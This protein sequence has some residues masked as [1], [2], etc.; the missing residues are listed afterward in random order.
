MQQPRGNG[1]TAGDCQQVRNATLAVEMHLQPVAGFNPD[2][3]LCAPGQLPVTTFF[4]NMEAGTGNFTFSAAAGSQRWRTDTSFAHSGVRAL[5]ANDSPPALADSSAEFANSVAVPANAFLHFAHAF[6]FQ[7]PNLDGGVLEFSTTGGATW[8][9]AAPLIDSNG[10]RA[11]I[12]AGANPLAGRA[13]FVGSSHGYISSRANLASLAGQSVRFRWRMGLDATTAIWGWWLDDVRIYTCSGL[14]ITSVTPNSAQQG[15]AN[16][17]IAVTGQATHFA[18][19]QTVATFGPGVIVHGTTV[20]DATH[21]AVHVSVPSDAA[22]GAREVLMTTGTEVAVGP[23]MFTVTPGATL[24]RITPNRGQPGQQNLT[25]EI[26]ATA[27]AHFVQGQTVVNFGAGV[28]VADTRVIDANH[29]AANLF[30]APDA[31]LGPRT[32]ML[33]TGN[34]L[35]QLTS[36]FLVR[37]LPSPRPAFRLCAREADA[38]GLQPADGV[39]HRRQHKCHRRGNSGRSGML[40]CRR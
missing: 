15:F 17:S 36:G 24:T 23:N 9:D 34:E 28:T 27:L 19:G 7:G 40:V 18:Q 12:A 4:D 10:Y 35:L 6:D 8:S 2:A 1:D 33:T 14:G 21:A 30:I 5:Y 39:G 20:I 37:R 16:L 31:P 25:V 32:V 29:V 11:T 38:V 22:V 26:S 3:P 13:A